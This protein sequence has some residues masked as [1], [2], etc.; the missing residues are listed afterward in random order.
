MTQDSAYVGLD[1]HN[2][3]SKTRAPVSRTDT[4]RAGRIRSPPSDRPARRR[5]RTE[6]TVEPDGRVQVSSA[7]TPASHHNT[8]HGRPSATL[9]VQATTQGHPAGTGTPIPGKGTES[10]VQRSTRRSKYPP[11]PSVRGGNIHLCKASGARCV[12]RDKQGETKQ[13]ALRTLI[14]ETY[15]GVIRGSRGTATTNDHQTGVVA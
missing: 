13:G 8:S 14:E 4:E 12:Q 6:H 10:R 11:R 9:T 7:Q 2:E 3:T 1:I 15:G 5:R